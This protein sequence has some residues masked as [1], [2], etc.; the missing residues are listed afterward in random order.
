MADGDS[1]GEGDGAGGGVCAQREL[2]AN[3]RIETNGIRFMGRLNHEPSSRQGSFA[4][5]GCALSASALL[6]S[7]GT[8]YPP[9]VNFIRSVCIFVIAALG[10]GSGVAADQTIV[11]KATRMFDGKSKALVQNGVVI[12][13]G[14]KIVD[15]GSNLPIPDG[16]RVIDLGDATLSPGFMD[17]HTHLTSDYSGN[18]NEL[19]LKRLE[20]NVSKMAYNAIPWARATI[21]AGFTTV[22]DVGSRIT[23]T[24]DFPD[25]SLRNAINRGI[26]AGPRMLSRRMESERLAATST[27]LTG[28][29]ILCSGASRILRMELPTVRMRFARQFALK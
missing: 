22:R 23:N 21:E 3:S 20:L 2:D 12:V 5:A 10:I 13:Q 18:Y 6:A 17:A 25:V 29:A 26:I 16:A 28:F 7:L 11:L 4:H 19:R 14:N 8:G 27:Q 24:H 15:A 9:S 1:L